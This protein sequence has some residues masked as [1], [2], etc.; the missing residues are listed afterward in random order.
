MAAVYDR[1]MIFE[2]L[3]AKYRG[4]IFGSWATHRQINECRGCGAAVDI[5]KR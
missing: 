4:R 5:Q 3:L 2:P 1:R